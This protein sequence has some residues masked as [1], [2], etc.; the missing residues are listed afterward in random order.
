MTS[1]WSSSTD[2][3]PSVTGVGGHVGVIVVRDHSIRQGTQ[4]GAGSCGG[5]G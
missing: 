4:C 5:G 2:G 3:V 1:Y